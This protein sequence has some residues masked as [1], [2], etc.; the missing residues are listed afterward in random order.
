MKI[1]FPGK[2]D[3]LH[4]GHIMQIARLIKKHDVTVAIRWDK[5]TERTM[6]I[7]GLDYI[8]YTIFDKKIDRYVYSGSYT[9]GFPKAIEEKYDAIASA[10]KEI[11]DSAVM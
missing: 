4:T 10:N 1:L 9:K 8:L 2:F 3:P 5:G 7:W 6:N 11:L